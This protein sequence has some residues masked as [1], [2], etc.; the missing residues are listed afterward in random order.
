MT[1]LPKRFHVIRNIDGFYNI[2]RFAKPDENADAVFGNKMMVLVTEGDVDRESKKQ[3][4]QKANFL[5]LQTDPE[6]YVVQSG[7]FLCAGRYF[8]VDG[9]KNRQESTVARVV[10]DR[11]GY[12]TTFEAGAV[13]DYLNKSQTSP[14]RAIVAQ[15]KKVMGKVNKWEEVSIALSDDHDTDIALIMPDGRQYL[16]HHSAQN[17]TFTVTGERDISAKNA[18]A[19]RVEVKDR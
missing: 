8:V 2:Y 9:H 15:S 13:A 11:L 14:A 10:A 18:V 4:T 6:R 12:A 19:N 3:L 17:T 7:R 5:N 16:I 1:K